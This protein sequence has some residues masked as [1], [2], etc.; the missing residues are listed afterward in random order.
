MKALVLVAR[1]LHLGTI[2][3]YGNEW[4]QTPHLDQLAAEGIVFDQHYADQ[5]DTAGA[6]RAWQTA[7]YR[8]PLA[9]VE[10]GPAMAEPAHL[11]PLLADAGDARFWVSQD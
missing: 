8:L 11:F 4:I 3:C 6:Q 10:E 9:R 1:G 5:P 7:C 2:G